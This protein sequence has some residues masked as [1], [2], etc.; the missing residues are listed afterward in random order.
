MSTDLFRAALIVNA[1]LADLSDRS[2]L[3]DELSALDDE[4]R[5]ELVE[6]WMSK[7]VKTLKENP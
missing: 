2:G 3:G 6:T 4:T 7:I 1:L 5:G